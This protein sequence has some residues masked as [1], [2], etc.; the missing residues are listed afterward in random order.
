MIAEV[1]ATTG[2][3]TRTPIG[4][5][6]TLLPWLRQGPNSAP[7][8]LY[9]YSPSDSSVTRTADANGIIGSTGMVTLFQLFDCGAVFNGS[10]PDVVTV[11][12]NW[13]I[14]WSQS[15]FNAFSSGSGFTNPEAAKIA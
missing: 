10:S 7:D 12:F 5:S 13:W 15:Y 1:K 11:T 2:S 4:G 9:S 14:Y 8:L 3:D 6:F